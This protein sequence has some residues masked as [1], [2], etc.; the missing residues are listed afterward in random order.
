MKTPWGPSQSSV[1]V[2]PGITFYSTASHGGYFV[3]A[4]K[5][6]AMPAMIRDIPTFCGREG[7]YEEDADWALLPFAFP[8][9]FN[10]AECDAAIST[11]HTYHAN[12]F[13]VAAY[14]TTELG[15]ELLSRASLEDGAA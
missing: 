8:H 14:F 11:V 6:K 13:D 10:S 9:H 2:A 3:A 4:S 7:W 1:P 12:K 5:R 15:H